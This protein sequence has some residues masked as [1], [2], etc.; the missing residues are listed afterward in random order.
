MIKKIKFGVDVD[1]TMNNFGEGFNNLYKKYFPDKTPEPVDDWYWYRRMDY[2]GCD[3]DEWF[4]DH[5]HEIC[6][7]SQPYQDA[8]ETVNKAYNYIKSLGGDMIV[9]TFQPTEKSIEETKN[10]LDRFGVLRDDIVFSRS[11]RQKWDHADIMI[12]DADKVIKNKP[13]SKVCIKI[14]QFWNETRETDFNLNDITG[15]TLQVVDQAIRLL[16]TR[17]T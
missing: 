17:Q 9:V 6:Q 7:I 12:D 11:A 15:L 4:D 10:W 8:I 14:K 5:K 2:N 13:D 3:P 1:G 16:E